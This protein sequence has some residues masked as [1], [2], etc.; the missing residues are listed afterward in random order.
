MIFDVRTVNNLLEIDE[1]YK[2]PERVLELMLD[3]KKREKTFK[4]FLEI[5]TDMKFDWFHEYFEDN[6]INTGIKLNKY[7]KKNYLY[8]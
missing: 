2:A 8:N 6:C 4:K 1:S 5:S 3:D 7:I